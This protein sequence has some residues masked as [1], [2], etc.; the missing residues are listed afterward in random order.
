MRHIVSILVLAAFFSAHAVAQRN[1]LVLVNGT[2][3]DGSG[4]ARVRGNLRMRDGQ[5]LDIGTFRP[6]AGET[7]MDVSGL[8]VAPGFVDIHNLSLAGI[9]RDHGAASQVAQGITTIVLGP[10]GTGPIAIEDFVTP[11]EDDIAVNIMTLVGHGTVR[12]SVMAEDYKRAATPDEIR[13]MEE[14]VEYAMR[15][16]AFGLSSDLR[17]DPAS[18]STTEEVVTLAKVAA[19]YGGI[20]VTHL[21]NDSDK[22]IESIHEAI[23]VGREAKIRVQISSVR[24]GTAAALEK[25]A[26]VLG[27][28]DKARTQGVDIAADLYPYSTGTG[29]EDTDIRTFYRHE[30]VMVASDGGLATERPSSAGA[31]PR[32][33]G[34]VVRDQKLLT[35][36]QA[37]RKISGLPASRLGLK[38]RG[39]LI[40]GAAADIAVFDPTT[41]RDTSTFENPFALPEGMKHVFVNGVMVVKDGEPTGA[42]PGLALR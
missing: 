38:D 1:G 9:R 8:I 14:H 21:R 2:I 6:A 20:F 23:T 28:I 39:V 4:K 17:A 26:Q 12:R 24:S 33:L 22:V 34:P 11:F 32:V 7:T 10:D 41:I 19:R 3:I 13:L 35:L 15:E 42:R 29:S 31:F 30:W 16:G 18:Y 27:E 37:V 40:K 5:I 36:E 25:S